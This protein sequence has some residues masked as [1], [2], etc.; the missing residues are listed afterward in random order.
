MPW[1]KGSG[2]PA[3]GH[4]KG[5]GWGGPPRGSHVSKPRA[6]FT[7]DSPTRVSFHTGQGDPAKMAERK[8]REIAKEERIAALVETLE[9]I[10]LDASQ[11]PM[12]RITAADKALDRL[13]GKPPQSNTNLNLNVFDKL[14]VD[15]QRAVVEA[16]DAL[17][18]GPDD[19]EDGATA[20]HH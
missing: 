13:A 16:L 9:T 5:D 20:T 7:A 6:P 11:I 4:G 17:G 2:I 19:A 3:G 1:P 12:A 15:E 18:S 14:S 8:R 10:A